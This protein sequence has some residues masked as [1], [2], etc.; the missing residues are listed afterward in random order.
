MT[1]NLEQRANDILH[2]GGKASLHD[3]FEAIWEMRLNT[4]DRFSDVRSR[5]QGHDAQIEAVKLVQ[6]TCP[7]HALEP[8]VAKIELTWAKILGGVT[9][10]IV[11]GG[12]AGGWVASLLP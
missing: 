12:G 4:Q 11:L 8:R 1:N 6:D 3:V 10:A 2:N 9:V 5:L 7:V